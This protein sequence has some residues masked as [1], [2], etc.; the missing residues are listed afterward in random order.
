MIPDVFAED[1]EEDKD[2]IL[3]RRSKKDGWM[4]LKS[5]GAKFHPPIHKGC[6]C[7]IVPETG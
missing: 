3:L 6:D 7:I 5:K 1:E 2:F 4:S